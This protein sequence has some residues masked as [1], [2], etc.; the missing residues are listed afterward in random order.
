MHGSKLKPLALV[1]L[2]AALAAGV[3]GA[4]RGDPAA[5]GLALVGLLLAGATWRSAVISVFLR[6]FVAIFAVEYVLASAVVLLVRGGLWPEALA[7]LAVPTSLPI[8]VG[9]FGLIVYG[10]SHLHVIRTITRI[11]DL[12]FATR[13]VGVARIWPFGTVQVRE[14]RLAAAAITFLI[15]INQ[16]QVGISVRLSFFNRDWF[17]AIQ[18]KNADAFWSLLFTVFLVWAAVYIA[19]A[20]VEYVVQSGLSIRWRRWLTDHFVSDWL[21]D[22]RHYRMNLAGVGADNPDQ[23]IAV[24]IDRFIDSTYSFSIRLLATVSSLVSFSIILWTISANFTIPGTE[25]V[26]PGF[27]F[28]VALLYAG[29]GTL[30]THLIGRTLVPLNFTQQRYEADFRFSLAR[31]RE[32]SEQVA[33]LDGERAERGIVMGRFGSVLANFWQIVGV[34][35]RL[36]AF[37]ASYGQISP[38]IPY[39]IAAP[40]YF[41]GKIQLG[42]MSQTAGA[43][44]N[45]EGALNFF[46][47]YYV[48][49]AEYKSVIDRLTTFN[50]AIETA[51]SIGTKPPRV[52]LVQK[53]GQTNVRVD[54]LELALPNGKTIVTIDDLVLKPGESTLVTGPS[55]SGK[56]TLLRAVSGIWPYGDGRISVPEGQS[57]MLLPQRPYIPMGTLRGA[58]TYPELSGAYDDAAL[59]DAL[60]AARLPALVDR[61]DEE[62]IWPQRLSGGEQQ[63]LAIARAL[64]AKPDWLFLDEATSALDELGEAALY[65]ML[66]ERLPGATIVSIGHRSTLIA[67]HKRH[68]QMASKGDLFTTEE[69]ERNAS[70]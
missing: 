32:Y 65:K 13:E 43:F 29:I 31:L 38:L 15:V 58:V 12:Y 27:L 41:A 44:G 37:T 3:V 68:L 69:V 11:A 45:V 51:G 54:A 14:N 39:V 49:L 67:M 61:L 1:V 26:I 16:A 46:V 70:A 53:A 23:R 20:I 7:D 33:L 50:D 57:V 19:S 56:S 9:V 30:I 8:T 10:A 48:S 17:N 60:T 63:R 22:H 5:L 47:S 2:A 34:R 42:Q 28:W 24:D 25:I 18:E 6:I 52:E 36:L 66:A 59:R 35:K 64:L 21:G 55:G 4:V 40:F 62:D